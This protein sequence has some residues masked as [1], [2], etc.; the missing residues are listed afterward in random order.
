MAFKELKVDDWELELQEGLDFR[1]QYGRESAWSELEAWFYNRHQSQMAQTVSPNVFLSTGDALLSE[2]TVPSPYISV[3]AN[4]LAAVENVRIL[5]ALDNQ[6]LADLDIPHEI[7]MACFHAFLWGR[8]VLKVGYDSEFGYDPKLDIGLA[9]N[10]VGEL[11]GLTGSQYDN[12]LRKI[13]FGDVRPGYP[14]VKAVAPHD[15]VVPWGLDEIKNAPWCAHR[16]VRHIEDVRAD[17]K[18]ENTR[19]L[20][21]SMSLEDFT[22][23]YERVRHPHRI[24]SQVWNTSTKGKP[25]YVELWEIHDRRSGKIKVISLGHDK[26]L[27][28]EEDA[29]QVDGLPFVSFTFVPSS[30]NFW[31]T[32]DT[33]YLRHIQ[34]ELQDISLQRA[35]QRR[36]SCLKF[37]YD[38]ESIPEAELQKALS[39]EVGIAV[40]VNG[41]RGPI[42]DQIQM[43]NNPGANLPLIQEEEAARRNG[44]EMVGFS[45]NQFGEFESAGRRTATEAGIVEDA[46]QRRMTRRQLA[47]ATT[48][49][50]LFK[51]I[52]ATVFSLWS[53]VQ[54][55]QALGEDGIPSWEYFV[56]TKLRGDYH[57]DISFNA[58]PMESLSSRRRE[59]LQLFQV[60]AQMGAD[61]QVL[62]KYL[63]SAFNDPEFSTLFGGV[64]PQPVGGQTDESGQPMQG[65][66][67]NVPGGQGLRV[68]Q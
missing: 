29:L 26:F 61:P 59:A 38:A 40:S 33:H 11:V 4:K 2:L 17:G 14:W 42:K 62:A 60:A 12:R 16:V 49:R 35:K 39:S 7:E 50:D 37:L 68:A 53:G 25:E 3:R 45:R 52:N 19:K 44:R 46:S 54:V 30:R 28:N 64:P 8:G 20:V 63:S 57:Y 18:Y 23:S 32:P 1:R 9:P 58:K 43:L 67:G 56:G 13:E 6:F 55:I 34:A 47:L 21:P 51:K 66:Q 10:S 41:D 5:E 22:R 27:R 15:F 48:Y 65:M 31:V 24:G 36:I